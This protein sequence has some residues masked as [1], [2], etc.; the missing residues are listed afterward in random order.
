MCS[1][2]SLTSKPDVVRAVFGHE[3]RPD[4]PPREAIAPT[5]PVAIVR[6]DAHGRRE[7]VLVRW[8]LIP[9]WVKDPND[10]TVLFNARAET[11][12]EKPSFRNAMRRRRCLFPADG[13]Y[14]WTGPKGRRRPYYIRR[15][16]D[17][18]LAFAGLWECWQGADGS[19]IESA[20]I[21]TVPANQT[22]APIHDRMPAVIDPDDFDAW[23]DVDR[24][25]PEEAATLLRPAPDN[26]LCTEEVAPKGAAR[27][28][29]PESPQGELF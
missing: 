28:R 15:D 12:A 13:F 1:R 24:V 17:A 29:A 20:V 7:F 16:D 23:L 5:A 26:L 8:G 27:A 21:L 25:P 6:L 11:A 4:F 3:N 2:Y 10:F 19:E 22:V 9:A 14:E 18:P